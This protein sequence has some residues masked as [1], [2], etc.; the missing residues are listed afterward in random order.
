MSTMILG[1][2]AAL[3]G[4]GAMSHFQAKPGQKELLFVLGGFC[5][6]LAALFLEQPRPM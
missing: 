5:C 6:L 1:V 2:G 4:G 3:C